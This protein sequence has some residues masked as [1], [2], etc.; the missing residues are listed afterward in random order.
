MDGFLIFLII[1]G[2]FC[3]NLSKLVVDFIF[4]EMIVFFKFDM[5]VIDKGFEVYW[6]VYLVLGIKF[7]LIEVNVIGK[8]DLFF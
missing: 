2:R 7:L 6:Y 4:S 1:F 3:G 8:Y 5:S